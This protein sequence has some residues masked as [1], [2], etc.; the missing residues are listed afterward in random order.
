MLPTGHWPMDQYQVQIIALQFLNGF[1]LYF[2]L[3]YFILMEIIIS[4]T[5][6]QQCFTKQK[7]TRKKERENEPYH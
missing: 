7:K 1:K 2:I 4:L 5:H 3:F 6:T